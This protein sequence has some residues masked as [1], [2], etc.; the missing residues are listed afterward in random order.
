MH[1]GWST[2]GVLAIAAAVCLLPLG[3]ILVRYS[4][5]HPSSDHEYLSFV[6]QTLTEIAKALL[7]LTMYMYFPA[8]PL[9]AQV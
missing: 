9:P 1:L 7:S 6:V 8:T 5:R 3:S 4:K 2:K